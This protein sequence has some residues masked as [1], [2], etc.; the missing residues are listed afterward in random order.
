M[1]IRDWNFTT[2]EGLILDEFTKYPS[3]I[4]QMA[5][6]MSM[7]DNT[8]S[9]AKVTI[10]NEDLHGIKF[11]INGESIDI[12]EE[13]IISFNPFKRVKCDGLSSGTDDGELLYTLNGVEHSFKKKLPKSMDLK[14]LQHLQKLNTT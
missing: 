2:A 10:Y 5:R 11:N 3:D 6:D 4:Q 12:P 1:N 14:I 9:Y 8:L 13:H 7:P